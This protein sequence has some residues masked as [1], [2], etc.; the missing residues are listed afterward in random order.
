MSQGSSKRDAVRAPHKE[1]IIPIQIEEDEIPVVTST[2]NPTPKSVRTSPRKQ[3]KQEE[4]NTPKQPAETEKHLIEGTDSE[5]E[6]NMQEGLKSLSLKPEKQ[7]NIVY[8]V[9]ESSSDTIIDTPQRSL[10]TYNVPEKIIIVLDRASDENCTN[11]EMSSGKNYTPLFMLQHA[12]QIFLFNKSFIDNRHEFALISLNESTAAWVHNFTN[13][14]QDIIASVKAITEF[15]CEPEDIFDLNSV[16]DIINKEV[17]LSPPNADPTIPRAEIVRTILLYGRSYSIPQLTKTNE[18]EKLLSS[19]Q[20]TVDV[21]MTHEPPD[22]A[23]HCDRIFKSLQE[24]DTKGFAYSF[25]VSRNAS[26]LHSAMGKILSH[27]LQRPY[28]PGA[29]YDIN[30]FK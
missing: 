6:N 25:S 3:N 29:K 21:V 20:F 9:N 7:K 16:F 4:Q 28:Q 13:S 24:I 1:R 14:A 27:P 17:D 10:P 2:S 30:S 15:P 8:D 11:F 18:I 26:E 19:P 5:D 23:N 12:L 22:S